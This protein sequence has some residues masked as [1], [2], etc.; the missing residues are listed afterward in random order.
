MPIWSKPPC[1]NI[2]VKTVPRGLMGWFVEKVRRKCGT[3]PKEYI[4]SLGSEAEV[5]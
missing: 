1:M 4:M 5:S 2:D 3:A